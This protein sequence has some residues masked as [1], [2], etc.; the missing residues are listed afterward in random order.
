MKL[1]PDYLIKY[2]PAIEDA[3]EELRLSVID[4]AYELIQSLDIDELSSDNIK[5][6]LELYDIKTENMS[7]EWL[8]NGKF[9]RLFASIQHHRTRL[10]TIKA[11]SRSGG[12]FEGLWTDDFKHKPS[13]NYKSI[14]ILRHY[15]IG[16]NLDGYFYISGNTD[17]NP[18]GTVRSS[19]RSA[20]LN[21]IIMSQA[22]PAGYTYLYLPWPRPSYPVESGYFYNVHMLDYDRLVYEKNCNHRWNSLSYLGADYNSIYYCP[23]NS[24]VNRYYDIITKKYG[25]TKDNCV[26]EFDASINSDMEFYLQDSYDV[27]AS[28]NYDWLNGSN[29]PW[30]CPY[31]IDYHYMNDMRHVY[32]KKWPVPESGMYTAF[33][34]YNEEYEVDHPS[35]AVKYTLD[36]SCLELSHSS[37]VF[38]SRCKSHV[39][40]AI[41]PPNRKSNDA[42]IKC[43]YNEYAII[44]NKLPDDIER[45]VYAAA[46]LTNYSIN[47]ITNKFSN[48]NNINTISLKSYLSEV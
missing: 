11:I 19:A 33:D 34:K 37:S 8:P 43:A 7:S 13:Y 25:S 23:E 48:I 24:D 6:K 46:T 15:Y 16:S 38:P 32:K 5:D 17:R 39:R 44:I 30:R 22:L 42:G 28:A 18:D 1:L 26:A 35:D 31:W 27:P 40:Y 45:F 47:F 29:T 41:T 9:Y 21:D 10:N 3:L 20:L 4:H 36:E 14:Q 12:Q 2:I